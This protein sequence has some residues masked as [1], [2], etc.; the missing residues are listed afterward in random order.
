MLCSRVQEERPSCATSGGQSLGR[1][2]GSV[3]RFLDLPPRAKRADMS[4][5]VRHLGSSF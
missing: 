2:G 4:L 1:A 3:V 5:H